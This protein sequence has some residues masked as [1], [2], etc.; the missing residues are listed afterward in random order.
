M[1]KRIDNFAKIS[2]RAHALGIGIA[3]GKIGIGFIVVVG[4][5]YAAQETTATSVVGVGD[6][7][8]EVVAGLGEA[9][10]GVMRE[11]DPAAVGRGYLGDVVVG[12]VAR[13]CE[14]ITIAVGDNQRRGFKSLLAETLLVR[15]ASISEAIEEKD[16][17][18]TETDAEYSFYQQLCFCLMSH[19]NVSE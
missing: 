5:L 17:E 4:I 9:V 2:V 6:G 19:W 14:L 16:A 1:A 8:A 10:V 7:A 11:L 15:S 12:G 3:A 13:N 18:S